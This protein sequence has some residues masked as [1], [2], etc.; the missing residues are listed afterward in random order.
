MHIIKFIVLALVLGLTASCLKQSESIDPIAPVK[1]LAEIQREGMMT[2]ALEAAGNTAPSDAATID[3]QKSPVETGIFYLKMK[4]KIKD[5]DVFDNSS[6][7]NGYES[8]SNAFIRMLANIFLK[9]SGGRTVNVGEVEVPIPDLNLDFNVIKS[10]RI[11]SFRVEY[12]KSLKYKTDFSFL[13][14]M[15]IKKTTGENILSYK[16]SLNQCEYDCLEFS[17]AN[18]NVLDLVKKSS[19]LKIVPVLSV[20]R[21]PDD[22]PVIIDGEI[23]LQIGLKLPF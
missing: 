6:I 2:T 22:L 11:N 8:L 7:Q 10:I 1:T 21:L 16:K 20:S 15:Q 4:Y 13:K 12:S 9:V 19:P 18:G 14:S 5:L 23:D 3:V 17:V